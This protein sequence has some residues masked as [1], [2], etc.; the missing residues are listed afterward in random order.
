MGDSTDA[1]L[2]SMPSLV[3]VLAISGAVHLINYYREAIKEHGTRGSVERAIGHAWKPAFLCSV[4]TSM[5]L[6]SLYTSELTPVRKFGLYSALGVMGTLIVLFLFLPAAIEVWH[7]PSEERRLRHAARKGRS[8]PDSAGDRTSLGGL[9]SSNGHSRPSAAVAWSARTNVFW[10]WFG[11]AIIRHHALVTAGCFAVIALVGWGVCRVETSIDLLKM[12]DRHARIL[13][14]YAWLEDNLGRL[15]PMELVLRFPPS[16]DSNTSGHVGPA[17][18]SAAPS[19]LPL[20]F[21]DRLETVTLI[22]QSIECRGQRRGG[23]HDVSGH[24]CAA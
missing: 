3:Y 19:T 1:V 7:K 12:F 22:Q 15:V 14:D 17:T 23:S 10:N 9:A 8:R 18:A 4:T 2:M 5:G 11:G 20:S 21:L 16:A 6:L 24:V 13:K